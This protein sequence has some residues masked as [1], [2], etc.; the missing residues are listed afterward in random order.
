MEQISGGAVVGVAFSGRSA[1]GSNLDPSVDAGDELGEPRSLESR[2]DI[3]RNARRTPH[4]RERLA[5]M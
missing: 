1:K 3:H 5:K 4:S 2:M